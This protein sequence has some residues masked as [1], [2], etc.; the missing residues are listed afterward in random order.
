[1]RI[2]QGL[3]RV[4]GG[5]PWPP[6]PGEADGEAAV[7]ATDI[8]PKEHATAA[9]A[10]PVAAGAVPRRGADV[11]AATATS[12]PDAG[13]AA[14]GASAGAPAGSGIPLRR[15]LPRVPGGDPWPLAEFAPADAPP[16]AEAAR[17]VTDAPVS[18]PAASSEAAVEAAPLRGRQVVFPGAAARNRGNWTAEDPV[19][20]PRV[21]GGLLGAAALVILGAIAVFVVRGILSTTVGQGFLEAY[22]GEYPLPEGTEAG[23]PPWVSWAHFF[24]AFLIV[25]I[26]RSGLQVRHQAKPPAHWSPR[27]RLDRK[28][29]ITLWFHQSLDVLWILNGVAFVIL[30]FLTGHWARIV[31][32][33]WDVFPNA[34]SAALQY[35]SLDWPV[36]NGWVNYNS[37]QQ[38]TYFAVVFLA[39][40][41]AAIT[42]VRMSGIWPQKAAALNRVYP[43][44]LARAIHLPVM[45]FFV[46]FII[47]H[48]ALVFATGAL[49]NLNHM[50]AGQDVVNWV[51]FGVFAV[52]I[53]VIVI[54]WIAARPLVLAPI[55][56][57]FGSVSSR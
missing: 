22:P 25:L 41:L 8:P 18:D 19:R 40:P 17:V 33:S 31:P 12:S 56:R 27:W 57:L 48:V 21:I 53:A 1:M 3:P 6:L 39:A 4:P 37:L 29:S 38:L 13:S 26:I 7:V 2:R 36:E 16:S 45:F 52:S 47:G 55:A 46:A 34:L 51:G 54:A 30:L 50:Y 35:V 15:G 24:N 28:I 11:T 23:F 10:Q 42:G 49:R 20:W 43:V 5:D 44:E 9:P 14:S 32:T